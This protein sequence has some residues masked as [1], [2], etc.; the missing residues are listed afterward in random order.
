[1]VSVSRK[2]SLQKLGGRQYEMKEYYAEAETFD[3]AEKMIEDQII[4][5]IAYIPE[6]ATKFEEAMKKQQPF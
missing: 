4:K 5:Y 3:E 6:E 2:I 1:M